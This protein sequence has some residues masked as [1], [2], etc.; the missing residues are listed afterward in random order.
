MQEREQLAQLEGVMEAHKRVM[1]LNEENEKLKEKLAA[2]QEIL[3]RL[4]KLTIAAASLVGSVDSTSPETEQSSLQCLVKLEQSTA[5]SPDS[6]EPEEIGVEMI[7]GKYLNQVLAVI[8]EATQEANGEMDL[9][10]LIQLAM[11][12]KQLFLLAEEKDIITTTEEG[13]GWKHGMAML[14]R[15][16]TGATA[17]QGENE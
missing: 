2:R 9:I 1:S 13:K 17:D 3:N 6:P 14:E 4:Q 5:V 8:V 15:I 12:L 16:I 11:K 7:I 10:S